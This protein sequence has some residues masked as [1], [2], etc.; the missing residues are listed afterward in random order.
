LTS[1]SQ[2]E[3]PPRESP[4]RR[5]SAFLF[6]HPRVQLS[7][8]LAA[9][10]GWLVLAYIGSLVVLFIAAFWRLDPFT[11]EIVHDYGFQNFKTLWESDVYRAITQR[12]V[13][14]AAAVTVTD[15]LLAFPIAFYMAKVAGP[16]TRGLLVVAILMPLWSSYL[17]KVYA[18][19]IILQEDGALN[20]SLGPL[21]LSGPGF[22][23]VA[24]WLVFSYLWLPF[25]ILPLYAG[26]ERVPN[27]MLEASGDLGGKA[28]MTFRRVIFPLALPALIAGSIFTFSLTLGDYITPQL[29]SSTQFIGNVVYANVGVANNLPFAAAFATVPVVIMVAYLLLARRAGAFESL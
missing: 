23:N 20:W 1:A 13:G 17:V 26:L 27:S 16:R 18:W 25:M 15:A 28:W 2:L 3:T 22:G 19:R 29:V 14:I 24:T 7:L 11:A 6:R 21:G 12:T 8:L 4:W 5:L 10:L 9:P